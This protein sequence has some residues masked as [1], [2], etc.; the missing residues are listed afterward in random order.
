[1]VT[2]AGEVGVTDEA[3][4]LWRRGQAFPTQQNWEA[5][6]EVLG[7]SV[8]ELLIEQKKERQKIRAVGR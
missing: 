4:R 3:L 6:A 8:R 1:M 5:L 7:I 2:I